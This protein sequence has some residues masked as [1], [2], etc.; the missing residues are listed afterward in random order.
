MTTKSKKT[1]ESLEK[2]LNKSDVVETLDQLEVLIS[3]VKK[4][5]KIDTAT[6]P[7]MLKAIKR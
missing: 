2:A 6:G 5:Q 4:A 3:K 1:V 7:I